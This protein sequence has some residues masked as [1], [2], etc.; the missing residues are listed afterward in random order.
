MS[1]ATAEKNATSS[2]IDVAGYLRKVSL[3][4]GVGE[5]KD[6][7]ESLE[8][9]LTVCEFEPNSV[10]IREKDIGSEM[11]FLVEG[12]ASVCKSTPDGDI[13]KVVILKGENHAFFGEGGLLENEARVATIRAET[14]CRCLKLDRN[15][16]AKF[17]LDQ[18]QW[19]LP[20]LTKIAQAVMARLRKSNEDLTLL[21]KALVAEIRGI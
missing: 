18:P 9:V 20:I 8:K 14:H 1:L 17:S 5:N 21:Y 4:T 6:A 3:F 10:I 16:F 19:A 15:A 11:Y 2:K 7:M 13:Y 12:E